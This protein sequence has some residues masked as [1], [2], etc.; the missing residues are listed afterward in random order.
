MTDQ[1]LVIFK[2]KLPSD[3]AAK[4]GNQFNL[5]PG[6]IR[7]ILAGKRKNHEV[8][9]A[10]IALKEKHQKELQEIEAAILSA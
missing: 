3:W 9:I 8:M 10:A 7:K 1:H 6:T 5:Q 4:L 2:E